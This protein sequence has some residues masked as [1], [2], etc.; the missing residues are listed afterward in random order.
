MIKT[1]SFWAGIF[2]AFGGI[3]MILNGN[4][5]EGVQM[6]ALG[7]STVCLRHAVEKK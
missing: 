2:T 1:K 7:I 3:A 6:I 4:T 5:E